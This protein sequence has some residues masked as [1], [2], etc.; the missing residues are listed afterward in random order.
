V[1]ALGG[2]GAFVIQELMT[3]ETAIL[4]DDVSEESIDVDYEREQVS[5][6]PKQGYH[7]GRTLELAIIEAP[8]EMETR[9]DLELDREIYNVGKLPDHVSDYLYKC[10]VALNDA[11]EVSGVGNLSSYGLTNADN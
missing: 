11:G 9:S 1:A 8:D 6:A 10:V 3:T 2:D 5:G 7:K 4:T